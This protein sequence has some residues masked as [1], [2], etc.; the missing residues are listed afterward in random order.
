MRE[1]PCARAYVTQN[2]GSCNGSKDGRNDARLLA[3]VSFAQ[4][5]AG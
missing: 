1:Q 4:P 5:F 2:Y 3:L